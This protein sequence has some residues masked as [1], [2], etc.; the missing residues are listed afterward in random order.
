LCSLLLTTIFLIACEEVSSRLVCP[1]LVRYS[2]QSQQDLD[3]ALRALRKD[4]L[5][6]YTKIVPYIKDYGKLRAACRVL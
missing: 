3:V 1:S 5:D 4:N 2:I 6:L